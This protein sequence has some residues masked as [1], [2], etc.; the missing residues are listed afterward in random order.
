MRFACERIDQKREV[1]LFFILKF[2]RGRRFKVCIHPGGK[3]IPREWKWLRGEY[4]KFICRNFTCSVAI[5]S[6]MIHLPIRYDKFPHDNLLADRRVLAVRSRIRVVRWVPAMKVELI[7]VNR[8]GLNFDPFRNNI[9]EI[10]FICEDIGSPLLH[11]LNAIRPFKQ[12]LVQL[13]NHGIFITAHSLY[14]DKIYWISQEAGQNNVRE[15]WRKRRQKKTTFSLR[16]IALIYH[17]A[18]RSFRK[19]RRTLPTTL[20]K[21]ATK[22]YFSPD[23]LK[24]IQWADVEGRVL[25]KSLLIS[26]DFLWFRRSGQSSPGR[27]KKNSAQPNKNRS[28]FFYVSFSSCCD[29]NN[30]LVLHN[31]VV[32]M[33]CSSK[34]CAEEIQ[35]V[36]R[37]HLLHNAAL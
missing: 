17:F 33:P 22:R 15:S 7:D 35:V 37:I 12:A 10:P 27:V 21:T 26:V 18:S 30:S 4:L 8:S 32:P 14:G 2:R 5:R 6:C 13:Q 34:C 28:N 1:I 36:L 3:M 19:R 24:A 16:I 20:H 9:R 31:R 25:S 11:V 29:L 23:A